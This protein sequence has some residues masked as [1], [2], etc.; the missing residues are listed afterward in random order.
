MPVHPG[1]LRMR[2][3]A[4]PRRGRPRRGMRLLLLLLRCEAESIGV[5]TLPFHSENALAH[6]KTASR[7]TRQV[8]MSAKIAP[9]KKILITRDS[10]TTHRTLARGGKSKARPPAH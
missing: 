6:S 10:G 1:R 4:I 3:G 7:S 5:N 8:Y 2:V 9:C